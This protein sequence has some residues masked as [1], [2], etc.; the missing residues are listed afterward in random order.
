MSKLTESPAWQ[1]LATHQQKITTVHMRDLFARDPH[2]F[3]K[4]SLQFEIK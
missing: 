4:F 1:A 2:R 3:E